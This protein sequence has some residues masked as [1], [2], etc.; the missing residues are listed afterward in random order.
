MKD[1]VGNALYGLGWVH[2]RLDTLKETI[3]EY[4]KQLDEVL[5]MLNDAVTAL[6]EATEEDKE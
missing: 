4:G 2:A 1:G 3:P 6:L 5:E